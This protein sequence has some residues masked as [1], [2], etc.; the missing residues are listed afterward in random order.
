MV[1]ASKG[2]KARLVDWFAKKPRTRGAPRASGWSI[3]NLCAACD[4]TA[5]KK[6]RIQIMMDLAAGKID[7]A[8][9]T[10]WLQNHVLDC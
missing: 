7:R 2:I 4:L 6:D 8:G 3:L 1:N 10:A 9:L 5:E